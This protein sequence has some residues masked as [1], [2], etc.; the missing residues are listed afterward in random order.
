MTDRHLRDAL[1][2]EIPEPAPGYWAEIERRLTDGPSE[3]V[4]TVGAMGRDTDRVRST[5]RPLFA[6]AAV[7]V[8]LVAVAAALFD[9]S[10]E[11]A[12]TD[13]RDRP[14]A[15]PVDGPDSVGEADVAESDDSHDTALTFSDEYPAVYRL[16]SSRLGVR[17][18]VYADPGT[19]AAPVDDVRG[20]FVSTGRVADDGEGRWIELI[21]PTQDDPVWA[22]EDTTTTDSF[23]TRLPP[24]EGGPVTL[25]REAF[26][27]RS[28]DSVPSDAVALAPSMEVSFTGVRV[29]S[30][31]REW[32][33]L[34]DPAGYVPA[35]YVEFERSDLEALDPG[36]EGP[37]YVQPFVDRVFVWY[38]RGAP[39]ELRHEPSIGAEVVAIAGAGQPLVRTGRRVLSDGREWLEVTV[40]DLASPV[41]VF[42]FDVDFDTTFVS[43]TIYHRCYRGLAGTL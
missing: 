38:D 18:P 9:R 41:W 28:P 22:A 2:D 24:L 25:T 30:Q 23:L 32:L 21:V 1:L 13:V 11:G 42:A 6:V 36:A 20:S 37:T 29:L 39:T 35:E 4:P 27:Q 15:T 31:N 3:R 14:D 7:L 43:L 12:S 33:Y 8:L 34:D 17:I 40:H 10:G 16:E 19:D 26:A 5:R